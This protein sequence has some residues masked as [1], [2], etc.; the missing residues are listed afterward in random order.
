MDS[1]GSTNPFK[2]GKERGSDRLFFLDPVLE[3]RILT[4]RRPYL[5]R[6]GMLCSHCHKEIRGRLYNLG[7]KF[8]DEYCWS[9]RYILEAQ[10]S[11]MERTQELRKKMVIEK[12]R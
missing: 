6:T 2:N 7:N 4:E 11:E 5:K 3:Q 9:L 10:E 1:R 8:F 12:D